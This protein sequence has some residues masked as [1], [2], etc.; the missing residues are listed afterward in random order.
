MSRSFH[1]QF[2]K[3]SNSSEHQ[4]M[5]KAYEACE[6]AGVSVPEEIEEYFKWDYPD[7]PLE[8]AHTPRE[9][10]AEMCE[11]VEID[12]SDIPEGTAVIRVYMAY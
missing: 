4:K 6:A 12:I 7:G 10:N 3:D 2:L 5:I 9:Y 8:I 11:G 1:T